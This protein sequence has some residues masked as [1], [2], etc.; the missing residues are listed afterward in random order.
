MLLAHLLARL[1][2]VKGETLEKNRKTPP[3]MTG[4]KVQPPGTEQT[5]SQMRQK[6]LQTL[7]RAE[8]LCFACA[9]IIRENRPPSHF[10][11]S[12]PL[13]DNGQ[14]AFWLKRRQTKR[15]FRH[16][17]ILIRLITAGCQQRLAP[18]IKNRKLLEEKQVRGA[19]AVHYDSLNSG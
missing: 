19:C 2:S 1:Y 9:P 3:R 13:F 4:Q 8:C 14:L 15:H 12:I 18:V 10:F 16:K 5:S 6:I 17:S 7:Q 11:I